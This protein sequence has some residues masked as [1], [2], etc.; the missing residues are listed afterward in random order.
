MARCFTHNEM[1]MNDQNVLSIES[2]KFT[3]LS[4]IFCEC[5]HRS[6]FE[7][8]A[9]IESIKSDIINKERVLSKSKDC[10]DCGYAAC[11][12]FYAS[13]RVFR[14]DEVNYLCSPCR[15]IREVMGVAI[16]NFDKYILDFVKSRIG[17]VNNTSIVIHCAEFDFGEQLLGWE[18]D[19]LEPI[20]KL[21][22]KRLSK[23]GKLV[24][25][26]KG[27]RGDPTDLYRIAS[28]V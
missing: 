1:P 14:L 19:E 25:T 2:Q 27:F 9:A 16:K 12:A 8:M 28:S 11:H 21:Y 3:L 10:E 4:P 17:D 18:P 15:L 6:F 7:R 23:D 26:R 24:H 5:N 20:I 22:L 13:Y